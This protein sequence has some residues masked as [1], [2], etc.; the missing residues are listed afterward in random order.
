MSVTAPAGFEAAGLSAGIKGSGAED[1][2]LITTDS[3]VPAAGVFTTSLTAAPPVLVSTEHLRAGRARAVIINS[4]AANAGTGDGGIADARSM[5]RAVAD[6]LDCDPTEVLV[7]S[8]GPIGGRLPMDR[9]LDAVPRLV[10]DLGS[11]ERHAEEAA[12]GIMTTDSV[13]KMAVAARQG[14][15]VGGMAKGAGMVRPDMATMLAFLTTDAVASSDLLASVL[16]PVVDVT[17]NSLNIDGCQSTNDT[18]FILASGASGV[19]VA[20]AE[21]AD[22]VA[23]VCRSLALQMAADAEGASKVVKLEISGASDHAA[24]RRIGMAIADSALVRSSFYGADPN[25]GRILA[26]AGVAGEKVDPS[27]ITITYAGTE[28]CAGGVGLAFDEDALAVDL[29]GDFDMSICVGSGDGAA[30][31]VTTDLTPDYVRFNGER[32]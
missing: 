15:S 9:I 22:A 10:A 7:C 20:E 2:T 5:T 18:V 25:W 24:A 12:R 13:P 28:V 31:V 27:A 32:S 17:F 29:E 3:A 14:W 8:T 19:R 16:R 4:G 26:A 30:I 1:M 23:Q 21:L 6:R 11:T